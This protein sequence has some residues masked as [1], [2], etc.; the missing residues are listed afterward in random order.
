MPRRLH[1]P[2]PLVWNL[3]APQFAVLVV[4]F[5][6]FSAFV[7]SAGSAGELIIGLLCMGISL[8]AEFFA[9]HDP[10]GHGKVFFE[11]LRFQDKIRA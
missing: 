4:T 7:M 11:A 8:G 9:L 2:V 6:F 10:S 1:Y 5:V 3:T